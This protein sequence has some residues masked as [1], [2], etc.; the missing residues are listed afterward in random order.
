MPPPWS[1]WIHQ[2]TFSGDAL[3]KNFLPFPKAQG[4]PHRVCL[5]MHSFKKVFVPSH[6]PA[7][8]LT[9]I[10]PFC[11]SELFDFA[12][13]LVKS[14]CIFL[15][16]LHWQHFPHQSWSANTWNK[17]SLLGLIFDG[18]IQRPKYSFPICNNWSRIFP[19]RESAGFILCSLQSL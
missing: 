1:I 15:I 14:N 16:A 5:G 17:V 8:L 7:T 11:P 4:N 3:V 2:W 9:Y 13:T 6:W 18:F 19:G 10:A 12:C